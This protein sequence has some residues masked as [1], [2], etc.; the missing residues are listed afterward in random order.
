IEADVKNWESEVKV[1]EV[2]VNRSEEM[3]KAGIN[4][5]QQ[6]DH[7]RYNLTATRYELD[8]ERENLLNSRSNLQSLQLELEK[9]RI[10]APFAG[11]VARRYVRQGE[12]VASGE[13]LFWV[14]AVEPLQV[15]FT[16]P[17]QYSRALKSGDPLTLTPAASPGEATE[18]RVI[19]VSPVVDP[20]SGTVEVIAVLGKQS[21]FRPGMTASIQ[22]PKAP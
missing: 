8:R 2:D 1:R 17:E 18:A 12:R 14:T 15:R 16:L 20:A 21:A 11:I 9:T 3:L 10:T 5:Q 4:T 6:V 13:K 7:D 19:H 22:V